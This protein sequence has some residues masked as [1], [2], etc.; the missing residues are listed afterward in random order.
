[1]VIYTPDPDV[2]TETIALQEH[3]ADILED[4]LEKAHAEGWLVAQERA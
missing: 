2:T 1:M 4:I 3:A